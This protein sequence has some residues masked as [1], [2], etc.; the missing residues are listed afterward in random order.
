LTEGARGADVAFHLAGATSGGW[1]IHAAATVEGTRRMLRACEASAVRRFVLASSIVVYDKR[2]LDARATIDEAARL[3]EPEP[4]AGA[5]A[6]GKLEAEALARE[7]AASGGSMAIVVARPG[8]IYAGERLTFSHLGEFLG[9]TRLAYGPPSLPLPLVEVHSC[10]DA[11]VR[12]ATSPAAA[13]KTYHIVDGH[14][15]TRA[16]YLDALAAHTGHGQRVVYLPVA[17]VAAAAGA[18]ARLAKRAGKSGDLSADKIR[19]R[20]VEV[21]YD[22]RALQN[23]TGWQPLSSLAV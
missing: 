10:V 8:L 18:A 11:L 9:G 1:D 2:G 22:T 19:S 12:L 5:Y 21:G 23:D 15:T 7:H 4:G 14:R 20:A 6:R 17:P 13:G 16:E 3:L